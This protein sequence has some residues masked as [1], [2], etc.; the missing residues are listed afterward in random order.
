[1]TG[2]LVLRVSH[3][4]VVFDWIALTLAVLFNPSE[5][6]HVAFLA[7]RKPDRTDGILSD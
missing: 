4:N 7:E 2:I 3:C 1:V 5:D 6:F